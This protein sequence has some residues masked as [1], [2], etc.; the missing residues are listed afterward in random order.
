MGRLWG[1]L[2]FVF[3]TFAAFS[4]VIAVFENI[5]ICTAELFNWSRKRSCIINCALLLVL[6]LPCIFG[7]NLLKNVQPLGDGSTIMDLED[8][9][10]SNVLLPLGSLIIVLF[11]TL[12]KGWGWDNFIAEANQ[13]NGLKI[14]SRLKWYMTFVLPVVV[15]VVFVFGLIK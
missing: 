2:F 15:I 12:K 10:V 8:F 7:F 6:S 1:S 9:I 5:I 13:G 14:S 11:C 4:T 3:L